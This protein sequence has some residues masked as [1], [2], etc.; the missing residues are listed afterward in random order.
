MEILARLGGR[1]FA[2]MAGAVLAARLNKVPV[3]V[4]GFNTTAAVAVL[5]KL[6]P[7]ALDHC[8]FSHCS[9]E[10]AH[11]KALDHMGKTALLDL[12]MRLGEGTGAAVAAGIVKAACQ[13]HNG[14]AT[15]ADVGL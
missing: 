12:G 4:D 14:M 6:N 2:A 5:H 1:E 8:I 11:R 15:F 7:A 13:A 3:I 9:A 10:G